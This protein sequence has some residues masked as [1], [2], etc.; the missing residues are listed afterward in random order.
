MDTNYLYTKN[1]KELLIKKQYPTESTQELSK[2]LGVSCKYIHLKANSMGVYKVKFCYNYWT[3]E[4]IKF[5]R[6]NIVKHDAAF[7]AKKLKRKIGAVRC[8]AEKLN[9]FFRRWTG[10]EILYLKQTY[11]DNGVLKY[12]KKFPGRSKATVRAKAKALG[13][14]RVYWTRDNVKFLKANYNKLSNECLAIQLHKTVSSI[15]HKASRLNIQRKACPSKIEILIDFYLKEL[16]IAYESQVSI[17]KFIVDFKINDVIIECNGSY[18]HADPR[19]YKIPANAMQRQVIKK[20]KRRYKHLKSKK[21]KLIILWEI[22]INNNF[23]EITKGIHAVLNGD[24][25]YYNSAKS[26]KLLK[27][28]YRGKYSNNE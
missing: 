23:S 1:E 19:L 16:N 5:L 10:K 15:E 9:L 12:L 17:D 28:Q 21:F 18:W 14:R 27:G 2:K 3:S 8:K 24:I 7:I 20:D 26:V 25:K 13:L 22:D 6:D 4:D 11:K